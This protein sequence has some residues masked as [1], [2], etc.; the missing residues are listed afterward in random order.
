MI[1]ATLYYRAIYI[2]YTYV[3]SFTGYEDDTFEVF[4]N[5]HIQGFKFGGKFYKFGAKSVKKMNS[6]EFMEFVFSKSALPPG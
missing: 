6:A 1:G 5:L 3:S 4:S 2:I